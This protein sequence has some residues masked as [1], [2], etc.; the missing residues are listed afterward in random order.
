MASQYKKYKETIAILCELGVKQYKILERL[1]EMRE[2]GEPEMTIKGISTY[3]NRD[4][5]LKKYVK[6]RKLVPTA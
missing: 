5:D 3:I 6:P 1:N 2:E 4:E